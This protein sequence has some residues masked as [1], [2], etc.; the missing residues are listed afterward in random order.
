MIASSNSVARCGEQ[1]FEPGPQ[2]D[3]ALANRSLRFAARWPDAAVIV[4]SYGFAVSPPKGR[5]VG[6]IIETIFYNIID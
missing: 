6:L 1:I 4:N 3:A 2:I 5:P